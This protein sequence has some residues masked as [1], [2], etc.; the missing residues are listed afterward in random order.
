MHVPSPLL[1][2]W[3]ALAYTDGSYMTKQ[4]GTQRAAAL[5]DTNSQSQVKALEQSHP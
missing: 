4:T 2:N 5:L 1:Y 3:K